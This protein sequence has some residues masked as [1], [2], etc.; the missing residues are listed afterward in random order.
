ME[1]SMKRT[2]FIG[3]SAIILLFASSFEAKALTQTINSTIKDVTVY[4]GQAMITRVGSVDLT[5]G[6]QSVTIENIPSGA[7]AASFQVSVRGPEGAAILGFN[8]KEERHLESRQKKALEL[9][10]Q[11]KDLEQF[12]IKELDDRI[13]V[14]EEQRKFLLAIG[15]NGSSEMNRQ[16]SAGAIDIAKWETAFGFFGKRLALVADSL[17]VLTREKS[18][19]SEKLQL[20]KEEL[21]SI[22]NSNSNITKSVQIDL[23]LTKGG[24]V[25]IT[26]RYLVPNA[27]WSAVY[28]AKYNPADNKV[29]LNYFAEVYQKT[30]EDWEN[31]NLVLSTARPTQNAGPGKI[32][33][34]YLSLIVYEEDEHRWADCSSRRYF[35]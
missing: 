31:I 32:E 21:A 11:I 23:M 35:I 19:S 13:G 33:P 20:L 1:G 9:E 2:F 10:N 18:S 27:H 34:W 17:R 7:E 12:K 3:I 24:S 26:L 16:I 22:Q 15:Q 28:D 30:G 4:H 5:A 29:S 25:E 8:S 6:E 14:L